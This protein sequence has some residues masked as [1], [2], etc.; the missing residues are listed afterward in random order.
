MRLKENRKKEGEQK[1]I[2]NW[3]TKRGFPQKP[4]EVCHRNQEEKEKI[5]D[6]GN[7]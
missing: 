1:Y 5:R 3:E 7:N 6:N 4:R 2:N